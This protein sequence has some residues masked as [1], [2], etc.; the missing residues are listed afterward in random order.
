MKQEAYAKLATERGFEIVATASEGMPTPPM[1][2]LRS[3]TAQLLTARRQVGPASIEVQLRDGWL[4]SANQVNRAAA[5]R[6]THPG[7]TGHAMI[8]ARPS[9][10]LRKSLAAIPLPLKILMVVFLAPFILV[11]AWILMVPGIL[12]LMSR[13]RAALEALGVRE[14]PSVGTSSAGSLI[15]WG[16]DE[17]DARA[18]VP[19]ALLDAL[20]STGWFGVVEIKP[21]E[22][23]LESPVLGFFAP[24]GDL[25]GAFLDAAVRSAET[26]GR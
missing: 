8:R 11:G 19:P 12:W 5:A 4:R 1:G 15:V 22:I 2:T 10:A 25:F 21:G 13:Q 14:L 6:I 23:L 24:G 3:V 26:L 18:A 20:T 7:I 16:S 17:G 9:V